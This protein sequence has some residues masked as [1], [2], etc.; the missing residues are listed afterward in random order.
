MQG[1]GRLGRQVAAQG[2]MFGVSGQP[3]SRVVV[4]VTAAI[5]LLAGI[6]VYVLTSGGST[7]PNAR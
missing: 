3:R 6:G 1:V 4:A 2:A 7:P 5:A